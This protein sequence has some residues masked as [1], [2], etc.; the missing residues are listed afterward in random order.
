[1]NWLDAGVEDQSSN[2]LYVPEN[3][4]CTDYF[5]VDDENAKVAGSWVFFWKLLQYNGSLRKFNSFKISPSYE[6]HNKFFKKSGF[7]V[8][9]LMKRSKL[10]NDMLSYGQNLNRRQLILLSMQY[11]PFIWIL[12]FLP[13]ISVVLLTHPYSQKWEL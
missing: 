13:F 3:L 4:A 8:L 2:S 9:W 6:V 11:F 10:K 5:K 7:A 12:P 1:M